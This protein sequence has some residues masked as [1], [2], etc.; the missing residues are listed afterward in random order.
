MEREKIDRLK[1][2]V[3]DALGEVGPP[4]GVDVGCVDSAV[5]E[6]EGF[7]SVGGVF[8]FGA[9]VCEVEDGGL[10]WVALPGVVGVAGFVGEEVVGQREGPFGGVEVAFGGVAPVAEVAPYTLPACAL[11]HR[12]RKSRSELGIGRSRCERFD[13]AHL[14][15]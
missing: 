15:V 7:G 11:H 8:P 12:H 9:A 5:G 13:R 1:Q 3:A 10:E 4:G 14:A 2:A 6:G